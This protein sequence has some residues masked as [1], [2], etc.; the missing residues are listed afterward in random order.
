MLPPGFSKDFRSAT[1]RQQLRLAA[2]LTPGE[3]VVSEREIFKLTPATETF[4]TEFSDRS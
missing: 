1:I 3:M 2:H 4:G